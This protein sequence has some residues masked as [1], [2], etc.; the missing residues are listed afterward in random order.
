MGLPWY[1]RD[2]RAELVE[3]GR[4]T[5]EE[6]GAYATLIDLIHAHNGVD[7][8]P[9]YIAG[10]LR[11]HIRI[12]TRIRARLIELGKL[13]LRDGQLRNERADREIKE[14]LHRWLSASNAGRAS[15][16][17]RGYSIRKIN[18]MQTTTVQRTLELT[19]TTK[20]ESSYLDSQRAEAQRATE[21]RASPSLTTSPSYKPSF[22]KNG[23]RRLEQH[24]N[25]RL[26]FVHD[27]AALMPALI[28]GQTY[29]KIRWNQGF[30]LI[31]SHPRYVGANL[32]KGQSIGKTARARQNANALL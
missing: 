32:S 7:D 14:G 9:R 31:P 24:H 1:K 19:T 8:D 6:R 11:V 30:L 12:W 10:E 17:K 28:N 3:M 27:D 20:K 26:A 23:G 21:K 29:C 16:V 22:A 25:E 18:G 2:P 4:L 13:Y 5:L 15:A